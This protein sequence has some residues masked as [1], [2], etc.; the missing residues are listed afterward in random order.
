MSSA[1]FTGGRAAFRLPGVGHH[2]VDARPP[3]S[4]ARP[5]PSGS[6]NPQ[7]ESGKKRNAAPLL[8]TARPGE[9]R[10]TVNL[11]TATSSLRAETPAVTTD[12]RAIPPGNANVPMRPFA[13]LK[14]DL[15]P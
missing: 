10:R 6:C 11:L 12:A 3:P 4:D 14:D 13:H 7:N 15:K 1:A 9:T 8:P 2:R 5:C